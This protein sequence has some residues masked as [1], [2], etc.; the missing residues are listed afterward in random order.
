MINGAEKIKKELMDKN[1][2]DGPVFKIRNDPRLT[3]IGSFLCHTGLDELTQILNIVKGDMVFIGPRPL[4]IDEVE[5]IKTKYKKIRENV[6]PGLISP[7]ILDGYH[8]MSFDNW[9]KSDLDYVKRKSFKG[10]V[11][12]IIEGIFLMLR[13]LKDEILKLYF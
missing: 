13:L 8:R 1:E 6:F 2:A 7:W 4:P 3:K 11:V 10:D 12:L 5:Q 9:M